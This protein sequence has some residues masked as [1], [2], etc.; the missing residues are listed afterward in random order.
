MPLPADKMG[1]GKA[2]F[3]SAQSAIILGIV[4]GLVAPITV[5][6]APAEQFT[7]GQI[8]FKQNGKMFRV[9]LQKGRL[10]AM[11]LN[12]GKKP[13]EIRNMSLVFAGDEMERISVRLVNISGPK[14]YGRKNIGGFSVQTGPGGHSMLRTDK[15]DCTFALS[16]I[17]KSKIEGTGSCEGPFVDG[18]GNRGALVTDVKFSAM[19]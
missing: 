12:F 3:K 19:P 9:P 8:E 6:A 18:R 11:P 16:R 2:M 4:L 14:Q 17:D 1:G 10:E 13:T 7:K 5:Q 15:G